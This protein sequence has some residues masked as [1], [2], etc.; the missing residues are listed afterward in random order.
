MVRHP[1][2]GRALLFVNRLM[3]ADLVGL[4]EAASEALLERLFDHIEQP[5]LVYAHEWRDGDLLIWD[6]LALLHGRRDFD[7][8]TPRVLR[9]LTISGEQPVAVDAR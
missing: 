4:D 8:E 6:N 7:P 3:T 1:E 5:A 9:R 2:S